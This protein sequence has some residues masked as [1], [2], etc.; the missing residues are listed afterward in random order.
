[1]SAFN[2]FVKVVADVLLI[3]FAHPTAQMHIFDK[4]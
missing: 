4:Q 3:T 2:L 1:M